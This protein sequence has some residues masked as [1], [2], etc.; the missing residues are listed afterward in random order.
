VRISELSRVSQVP[1]P[2][3][4]YYLREGLLPPGRATGPNQ[5][6]YDE[7]HLHRLRLIRVL[8]DVGGLGIASVRAVL[9]AVA[10]ERLSVHK[11][12]GVAHH[13]LG[14]PPDRGPVPDDVAQ[15]RKEVDAFLSELGWSVSEQAPSRRQLADALV[16]LRRLGRDTDTKAFLPYARAADELAA[17]ELARMPAD[18]PRSDM[19][20]GA[21]VGTVVFEAVLA[22]LRKLAQEHHSAQR[23][24]AP[25]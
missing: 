6:D 22:S 4:K 8:M 12:L 18:A 15:A 20:E 25:T 11:M 7:S 2:T 23:F 17:R 13:A 21:V 1:V 14:P 3:I 9:E 5:A 10:D 16:A 19:V 24:T